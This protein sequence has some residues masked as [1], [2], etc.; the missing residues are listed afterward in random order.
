MTLL[1][2]PFTTAYRWHVPD[3]VTFRQSLRFLIEQGNGSPPFRSGNYLLQR[4]LLVSDRA[5]RAVSEAAQR[6]RANKL[7]RPKVAGPLRVPS[8]E[9]ENGRP[10]GTRSVACYFPCRQRLRKTVTP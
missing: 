2:E 4:G 3:P 7:G 8:A 9:A 10:D 1:E 6:G 5:P